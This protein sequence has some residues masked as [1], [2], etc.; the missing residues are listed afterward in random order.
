M[1]FTAEIATR[2]GGMT[3]VDDSWS[4]PADGVDVHFIVGRDGA[5]S[6]R[7]FA[8]AVRPVSDAIAPCH[9]FARDETRS[10]AML[11]ADPVAVEA[12]LRMLLDTEVREVQ[13]EEVTRQRAVGSVLIDGQRKDFVLRIPTTLKPVRHAQQGYTT[14]PL[15]AVRGDWVVAEMHWDVG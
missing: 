6:P 2:F 13:L 11:T 9:E 3:E 8:V 10:A 15:H 7:Q 1:D 12:V 4:L 5:D 14:P